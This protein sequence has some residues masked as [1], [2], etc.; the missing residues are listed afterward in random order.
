M[1]S[2]HVVLTAEAAMGPMHCN[3]GGKNFVVCDLVLIFLVSEFR[4]CLLLLLC[5]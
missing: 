2:A 4:K 5:M 3:T 1:Q